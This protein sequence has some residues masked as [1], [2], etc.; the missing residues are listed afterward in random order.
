MLR[1][2]G[3]GEPNLERVSHSASNNAIVFAQTEIQP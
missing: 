3:F 1:V 2:G